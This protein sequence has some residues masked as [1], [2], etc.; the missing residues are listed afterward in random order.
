MNEEVGLREAFAATPSTIENPS[1]LKILLNLSS[2]K[3]EINDE[4]FMRLWNN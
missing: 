3:R 4:I 2:C 1:Q